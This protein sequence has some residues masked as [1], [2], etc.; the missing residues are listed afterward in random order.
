[1]TNYIA[2]IQIVRYLVLEAGEAIGYTELP[3]RDPEDG[4]VF[5]DLEVLRG[6]ERTKPVLEGAT[7]ALVLM[8][9]RIVAAR[10]D[11]RLPPE[12]VPAAPSDQPTIFIRKT[13]EAELAIWGED[14]HATRAARARLV[15]SLADGAGRPV[16]TEDVQVEARTYGGHSKQG[17]L[18]LVMVVFPVAERGLRPKAEGD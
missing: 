13:S 4:V 16:A 10:R 14:V 15:F 12:T 1:L 8:W 3:E 18:P 2:A 6:Y 5:G 9:Q 11:G 7:R 17:E